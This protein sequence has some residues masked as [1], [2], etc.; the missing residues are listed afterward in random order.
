[1]RPLFISVALTLVVLVSSFEMDLNTEEKIRIERILKYFLLEEQFAYTL[2]GSKPMSMS[3][4]YKTYFTKQAGEPPLL[5]DWDCW[6]RLDLGLKTKN[7]SWVAEDLGY[8]F[9]IFLI[10]RNAVCNIIKENLRLFQKRLSSQL[11]EKII[12][13]EFLKNPRILRQHHDLLGIILGFGTENAVAFNALN[14]CKIFLYKIPTNFNS[15]HGEE[16][17]FI[18]KLN[19]MVFDQS[20]FENRMLKKRYTQDQVK[21]K[22]VYEKGDF[23]EISLER[24]IGS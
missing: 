16:L 3:V 15:K 7:Y 4:I 8:C 9:Q 2:F 1:M 13:E 21:I 6:K 10:N 14:C 24:Y 11:D 5:S 20:S 23:L 22:E 19:F 17:F 18:R 12:L